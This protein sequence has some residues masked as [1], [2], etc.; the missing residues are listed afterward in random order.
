[1]KTTTPDLL[2]TRAGLNRLAIAKAAGIST[3]AREDTPLKLAEGEVMDVAQDYADPNLGQGIQRTISALDGKWPTAKEA[4]WL[5]ESGKALAVD[6]GMRTV[7]E[8]KLGDFVELLRSAVS[9]QEPK[10]IDDLLAK[11]T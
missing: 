7:G 10:A 6:R 9:A 8:E 5:G 2:A 11:M 3:A 1:V 4:V